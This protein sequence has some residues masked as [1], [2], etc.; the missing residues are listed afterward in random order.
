MGETVLTIK[1]LGL[2][3][4]E[5]KL[6]DDVNLS[7]SSGEL[8]ALLGENGTGK[9][10][11]IKI[12]TGNLLPSKGKVFIGDRDI[13]QMSSVEIARYISV[14]YTSQVVSMNMRVFDVVAIGRTPYL[15][16]LGKLTEKDTQKIEWALGTV[17]ILHLIHKE[18]TTLSD[19]ERQRVMIAKALAQDTPIMILDEPTAHLDVK[20]RVLLFK[21]LRDLAYSTNKTILLST[22]ELEMSLRLADKVWLISDREI[23][24]GT[25]EDLVLNGDISDAFVSND[26]MFNKE[27]GV[28][29]IRFEYSKS[30]KL[31]GGEESTRFWVENALCK[32]GYELDDNSETV[33]SLL[34]DSWE[35]NGVSGVGIFKLIEVLK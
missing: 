26:V 1:S 21:L 22:H 17:G 29:D 28:F 5:Q 15:G 33:I 20:N 27:K 32:I 7:L 11:L 23:K 4:D 10:S 6:F 14:V 13:E 8:V 24:E 35:V 3:F 2:T 25:P 19:G 9:S 31:S 12:L 16:L 18:V 34:R 30:V